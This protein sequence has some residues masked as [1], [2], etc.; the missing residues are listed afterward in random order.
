[1]GQWRGG[2]DVPS[3][4]VDRTVSEASRRSLRTRQWLVPQL[5][6]RLTRM[7][8]SCAQLRAQRE[9]GATHRRLRPPACRVRLRHESRERVMVN[10]I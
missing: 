10:C 5:G 7:Q 9:H 8:T 2:R 4:P 1:M 6:T 3:I